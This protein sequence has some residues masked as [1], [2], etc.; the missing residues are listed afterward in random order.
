MQLIHN[1]MLISLLFLVQPLEAKEKETSYPFRL[2]AGSVSACGIVPKL[3]YMSYSKKPYVRPDATEKRY[4]MAPYAKYE[5]FL[6]RGLFNWDYAWEVGFKIGHSPSLDFKKAKSDPKNFIVSIDSD[7][8]GEDVT[9]Y[10]LFPKTQFG[11]LIDRKGRTWAWSNVY[12]YHGKM[13]HK[14]LYLPVSDDSKYYY[15]FYIGFSEYKIN[16]ANFD[17]R[18]E[19][20]LDILSSIGPCE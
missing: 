11:K 1:L 3:P 19:Q 12:S 10:P 18:S 8:M 13:S 5:K 17:T 20:I 9:Q 15:Y 6:V 7:D 2:D 16:E 4:P 14:Y